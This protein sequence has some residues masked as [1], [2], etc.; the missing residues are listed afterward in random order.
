[1][2]GRFFPGQA[3]ISGQPVIRWSVSSKQALPGGT[4]SPSIC[5]GPNGRGLPAYRVWDVTQNVL[6]FFQRFEIFFFIRLVNASVT[7]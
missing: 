3:Q 7:R 1:M 2:C 4:S 6:Y 5:L